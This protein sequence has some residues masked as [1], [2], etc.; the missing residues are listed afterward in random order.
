MA[1]LQKI[2]EQWYHLQHPKGHAGI[3]YHSRGV[4]GYYPRDKNGGT[5]P[6]WE[7]GHEEFAS[8]RAEAMRRATYVLNALFPP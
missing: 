7:D 3:R 6:G 8:S 1:K 5:P 4:W 2:A